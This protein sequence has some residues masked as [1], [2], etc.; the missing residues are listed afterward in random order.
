MTVT[1]SRLVLGWRAVACPTTIHRWTP[2]DGAAPSSPPCPRHSR[3]RRGP[4][5]CALRRRGGRAG[6]LKDALARSA[7]S[8]LFSN[9]TN[10]N[11]KTG[12]ETRG[13]DE[14]T[15]TPVMFFNGAA[16]GQTINASHV[17]CQIYRDER[18][19]LQSGRFQLVTNTKIITNTSHVRRE[20]LESPGTRVIHRSCRWRT[21]LQERTG[22]GDA[23]GTWKPTTPTRSRSVAGA[24]LSDRVL[25]AGRAPQCLRQTLT[26]RAALPPPRE[27]GEFISSVSRRAM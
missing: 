21:I 24:P 13:L 10:A 6:G 12:G 27:G 3:L 20:F 19:S 2:N 17:N 16:H 15:L 1:G 4:H 23:G 26:L 5:G 18:W 11:R 7:N 22:A 14:S 9:V 25:G 8:Q